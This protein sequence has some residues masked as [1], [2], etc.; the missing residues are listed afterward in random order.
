M[1][2]KSSGEAQGPQASEPASFSDFIDAQPM[3]DIAEDPSDKLR[4]PPEADGIQVN[5]CKNPACSNFG[6]RAP[7]A[8]KRGVRGPYAKVSAGAGMPML[9]CNAC[10][11]HF[12]I[13]S[14]AGI[15]EE[16]DRMKAASSSRDEPACPVENC[17]N[18]EIPVSAGKAHY[19][20]FGK[21]DIGSPRWKC[22][23]CGKTF[24]EPKRALHRQRD[25]H[26]NKTILQ[27]LLNKM[28]LRRI[29]EVADIHPETLYGRI[30]FFHRQALAF[31]AEREAKLKTL[32]IE[33]LYLGVD[34]QDYSINWTR[35]EDRRNIVL[36]AVASA[37][38]AT[39]YVFGMHLNFDE[40]LDSAAVEADAHAA[41]DLA[42][43][44]PY[45]KHARLWL[46]T[47]YDASVARSARKAAAASLAG[48]IANAY[49]AAQARSDIE[50][51]EAFTKEEKLPGQGMQVHGEYTLYAHFL[52]LKSMMGNV[53]KWRFFLDQ[54]SPMRAACLAAFKDEIKD[55][56]ADAFFVRINKDLTVDQKRA[57]K[58]QAAKEFK[59]LAAQYPGLKQEKIVLAMI[60]ERLANMA[61]MG[62]WNDRW[63]FHPLPDM[64]EPEKAIAYL[65]DF[66]DYPPDHM[67]WLYNKASLQAADSYFM[68]IRRR[69]MALERPVGSQGNA[70]RVWNG[71]APYNPAMV[72]K[73]LDIFRVAHNFVLASEKDKQTPAMRLGLAKAPLDYED[74]IYFV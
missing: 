37:D 59:K 21:T 28:P 49:S 10:G 15:A 52:Y 55:R 68:Q 70:G 71:Y 3:P 40:G 14:N 25:S 9:R 50:S 4:I 43:A 11:E 30:A 66:G 35:R 45:R 62:K 12:P 61:P 74:I 39:R 36:S 38:N 34:R 63:L 29:C 18:H 47:D 73:A 54:D 17:S 19:S 2:K 24:S 58:G 26:K 60:Q 42:V 48:G 1:R 53:E 16:L 41:G 51:P 5:F 7:E 56:K 44:A 33:R 69:L 65:T 32:P 67:A 27:L 64:G 8:A 31:A 46:K 20:S 22:K 72:Q 13:K 57:R 6:V 23:A